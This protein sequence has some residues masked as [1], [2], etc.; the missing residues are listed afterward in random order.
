MQ[1]TPDVKIIP[2]TLTLEPN[3]KAIVIAF[4]SDAGAKYVGELNH[5]FGQRIH[6]QRADQVAI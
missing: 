1:V 5:A 3:S 6:I 2:I 4:R